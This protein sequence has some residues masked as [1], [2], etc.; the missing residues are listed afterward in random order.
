MDYARKN[1]TKPWTLKDLEIVLSSLKKNKSRDPLGLANELF[2]LKIAGNDMKHAVLKLMNQIK[3][4]Q[5]IPEKM[6]LCNISSIW[7]NKGSRSSF[8][9]Y[10]GIFRVTILRTILDRLIYNDEY[11]KID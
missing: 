11:G 3:T 9:N 4:D 8:D 2:S 6:M 10:R 5:V 7:K 1:I